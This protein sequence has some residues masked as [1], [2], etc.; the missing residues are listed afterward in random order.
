M[1]AFINF[2]HS[3]LITY[4]FSG[5]KELSIVSPIMGTTRDIV[6]T[7]LDMNGYVVKISDTAGLRQIPDNQQEQ[8]SVEQEG[9]RR[10]LAR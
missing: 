5:Q 8:A 10:A 6:E 2:V 9:I 4:L 7:F 1:Y 3:L